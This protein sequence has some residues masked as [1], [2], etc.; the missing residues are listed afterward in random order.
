M[1]ESEIRMREH[2]KRLPHVKEK[3]AAALA[4]FMVGA[5]MLTV[6]TF[7]W[8][9]LSTSPE[10]SN[11]AF[12]ISSNGNLEI[13]LA[14]DIL[15]DSNGNPVYDENGNVIPVAPGASQVG[16]SGKDLFDRNT[17]WGNLVNLSD[18]IYGL[19]NIVLR[20]ATL[21]T[22]ALLSQPL[23]AAKYDSDGRITELRSDFAYTQWN[24]TLREFQA[25]NYKGIKAISSVKFDDVQY[26][27]PLLG[28]YDKKV[29][30]INMTLERARVELNAI[31][32]NSNMSA[33][34]GLMSTYMN[35]TLRMNVDAEPCSVEDIEKFYNVMVVVY[36]GP[37]QTIGE[38]YMEIIELYQLDTY[39]Q[40]NS[41]DLKYNRFE[42]LDVFCEEIEAY[43]AQ[44]N[45]DRA[46][47]SKDAIDITND[48]PNFE[49]YL[50]DRAELLNYIG[51]LEAYKGNAGTTWGDIKHIVNFIVDI[52]TCEINGNTVET[53][54]GNLK[55]YGTVLLGMIGEGKANSNSAVVKNGLMKRLDLM[56]HN[57][58]EGFK[59]SKATITIDKAALKTRVQN[60][61][62]SSLAAMV[63][64]VIRGDTG[65]AEAN[66]KT[67]AR[68]ISEVGVLKQDV[69]NAFDIV[70][71]QNVMKTF[72]AKDTYGLSIDFWVRTNADNSFL[73][74]EGT[75]I[76]DYIDITK[77]VVVYNDEGEAT[78][79][80]DVQIYVA[81]VTV[82]TEVDG[83]VN[84][85]TDE[86]CEVFEI[87]GVWYL[88]LG[89]EKL[90]QTVTETVGD[91]QQAT[92][93][94]TIVGT[95]EKKQDKIPS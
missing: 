17:T 5:L 71:A 91:G 3:L 7:S 87:N 79:Y 36:N 64:L 63:D 52:D 89:S 30:N 8:L 31:S 73:V 45:V 38:A 32:S 1:R 46:A 43:I 48:I 6:V 80:S 86:A 19:E 23:Y 22:N 81:D 94:K 61:S 33:I 83:A 28:F 2:E 29:A 53:L 93:T 49:Q 25:S 72:V 21:N 35:G 56:L 68:G 66:I 95:P 18:D 12:L 9:T 55:D 90:N 41:T 60:S 42:N 16:D 77:D 54:T 11:T 10:V 47:K 69:D 51:Q 13:A 85:R 59:I 76:Y 34:D 78:N 82:T 57:G 4:L 27:N 26:E 44:M 67:D 62:M 65:V 20:P 74:L 58:I 88:Y 75:V 92:I 50:E 14:K 84:T 70:G 40:N 15:L 39:G 37:M 24:N